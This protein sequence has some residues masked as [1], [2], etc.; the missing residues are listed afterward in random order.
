MD[1]LCGVKEVHPGDLNQGVMELGA[2]VCTPDKPNCGECPLGAGAPLGAGGGKTVKARP[3]PAAALCHSYR[4]VVTRRIQAA[5]ASSSSSSSGGETQVKTGDMEDL[6]SK[7]GRKQ[8]KKAVPEKE[9]DVAVVIDRRPRTCTA[10]A[11]VRETEST[12]LNGQ[13]RFPYVNEVSGLMKKGENKLSGAVKHVFS[14]Q[15]HYYHV[16]VKELVCSRGEAEKA[17]AEGKGKGSGIGAKI[18]WKTLA[19]LGKFLVSTGQNKIWKKVT[20]CRSVS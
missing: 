14:S 20:E 13:Y 19:E 9:F 12:L 3:A 10:V 16:H 11:L 1:A 17:A 15:V 6:I 8:K 4:E 2:T 5:T 18:E 7:I